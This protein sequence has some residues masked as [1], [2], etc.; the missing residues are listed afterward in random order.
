VIYELA[1]IKEASKIN[2]KIDS[3]VEYNSWFIL[4]IYANIYVLEI[5]IWKYR[6]VKM[7]NKWILIVVIVIILIT[8]GMGYVLTKSNNE[9][10][11]ASKNTIDVV[12]LQI[13]ETSEDKSGQL[14][15]NEG[16]E[17]IKIYI[18]NNGIKDYVFDPSSVYLNTK[19]GP[20]FCSEII[21]PGISLLTKTI[22]NPGSEKYGVLTYKVS[23]YSFDYDICFDDGNEKYIIL[24]EEDK[25]TGKV[26]PSN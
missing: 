19:D 2:G 20:I 6:R 15:E 17:I 13:T 16:I 21:P 24:A 11:I 9:K 14:K 7:R 25:S 3:C 23:L 18:K 5:T 1:K 4:R 22:I 12:A 8:L 10:S 26:S